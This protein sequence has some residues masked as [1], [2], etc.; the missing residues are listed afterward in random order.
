MNASQPKNTPP[1]GTPQRRSV[2]PS[3]VPV[4]PPAG[5][6]QKHSVPSKSVPFTAPK[7]ST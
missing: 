2:S 4:K 1:Q 5:T 7:K 6:P 3:S